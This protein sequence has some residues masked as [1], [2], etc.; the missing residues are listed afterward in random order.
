MAEPSPKNPFEDIY[1]QPGP[2]ALKICA[3]CA[4]ADYIEEIKGEY[5]SIKERH[6]STVHPCDGN[7]CECPM[8]DIMRTVEAMSEDWDLRDREESWPN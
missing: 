5:G 7:G 4:E 1:N 2:P 6:K 8:C 3:G